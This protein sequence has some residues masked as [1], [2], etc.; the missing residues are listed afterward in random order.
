MND[1]DSV[2]L[3]RRTVLKSAGAVAL[4]LA[5][6]AYA[7]TPRK[8]FAVVGLGSRS[9]MY[10]NAITGKFRDA[11]ELVGVS[12]NN[13]G[14]AALAAKA[15]AATGA[16]KPKIYSAVDFDRMIRET[17]PQTVIVTS[18]DATHNDYIVRALDAGCDVITE[19]PMTTTAEKAQTIL[20]ACKRNG[21]HVRVTFNYRYSPP[22]TQIKEMLMNGD[23]GDILSVDFNW[24][25]NTVHGA[26]YFRRWHSNK[27]ISGG[28]MIHKATHHFDLVNWWLGAQPESVIAVGKRE[29]YTPDMARRMGLKGHHERCR[30]CPERAA[31]TFYFDLAADP[32][33][34]ALY[35]DNEQH[36]GYFRDQCVWRPDIDIEDTMNVVV[37]YDT[38]TTLSYS[39]NAFNSW[40]G[41]HI[42]FNGT[43]G[44]IEH[45]IV[46]QAGVAGA[47]ETQG[48]IKDDGVT[49]RIIP[50]RGAPRDIEPWTG[51]GG[52]GGGDDVM[53]NEIFGD[54]PADKYKRASDERG[55]AYSMLIG[56]AANQC[57]K[58]GQSVR[59]D[60]LVTGLTPA[61]RAPMPSRTASLPMPMRVK[62]P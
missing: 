43:K 36:D 7:A 27:A 62:M 31:C 28:L 5:S 53:L 9:R 22:R 46:E 51:T 50:L 59:I 23:I 35:L 18:P 16:S 48:K 12:D 41:Y 42:A 32:G 11:N 8:R 61:D 14:R 57:F 17:K 60:Q 29:F 33:L 21:R 24:L 3:D 25:L 39:L 47:D 45:S 52:H 49:T 56:A 38:G 10:T 44:R 20:D 54:A 2:G 6:T 58:T 4:G 26:D 19:K 40:E 1:K 30:T 55:G 37:R 13:A 15:I 34:K